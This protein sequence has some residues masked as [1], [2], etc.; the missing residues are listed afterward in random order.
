MMLFAVSR[1]ESGNSVVENRP[2]KEQIS[3]ASVLFLEPV[4]PHSISTVFGSYCAFFRNEFSGERNANATSGIIT[5]RGATAYG[6]ES[7]LITA[8]RFASR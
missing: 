7:D 1:N 5:F 2:K 6:K 3:A 8:S 4:L